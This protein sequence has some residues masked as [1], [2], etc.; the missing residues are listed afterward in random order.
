M[1][2]DELIAWLAAEIEK[3]KAS[4]VLFGG[5][6]GMRNSNASL[7]GFARNEVR[8]EVLAKFKRGGR[9]DN[10]TENL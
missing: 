1:S 3:E 4:L 5:P 8:A 6:T 10:H 2:N 9:D 7:I